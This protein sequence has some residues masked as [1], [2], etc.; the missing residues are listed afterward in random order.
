[1][2][3]FLLSFSLV[4]VILFISVSTVSAKNVKPYMNSDLNEG[5]K[6]QEHVLVFNQNGC[7]EDKVKLKG[8]GAAKVYFKLIPDTGGIARLYSIYVGWVASDEVSTI[9]ASN[10]NIKKNSEFAKKSYYSQSMYVSGLSSKAG[11]R[12]IGTAY[13]PPSVKQVVLKSKNLSLSTYKYGDSF[14]LA[15]TREIFNLN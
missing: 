8:I 3:R 11:M 2:K 7:F 4:L 14:R 6:G 13:I 15:E 12:L 5:I 10:I 1:M 9:S